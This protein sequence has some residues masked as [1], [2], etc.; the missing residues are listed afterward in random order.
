MLKNNL[1]LVVITYECGENL[2]QPRVVRVAAQ[3]AVLPNESL[4]VLYGIASGKKRAD[5]KKIK[6]KNTAS[7]SGNGVSLLATVGGKMTKDWT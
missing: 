7:C 5:R 4:A 6:Y 3:L 1:V 2:L